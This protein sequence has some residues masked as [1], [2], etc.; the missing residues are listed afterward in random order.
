MQREARRVPQEAEARAD[1]A[2][3]VVCNNDSAWASG[4]AEREQRTSRTSS[5]TEIC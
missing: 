2:F 4:Q 3:G 1:P 5:I